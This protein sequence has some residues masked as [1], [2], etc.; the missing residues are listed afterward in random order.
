MI[1]LFLL[2]PDLTCRCCQDC[3][4]YVAESKISAAVS[5]I[6]GLGGASGCVCTS[7][8]AGSRCL[9]TRTHSL[10]GLADFAPDWKRWIC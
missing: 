10:F 4:G 7:S 6:V 2:V 5:R 1:Q 8:R 3:S 9:R